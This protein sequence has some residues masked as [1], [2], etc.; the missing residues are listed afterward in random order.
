MTFDISTGTKNTF[1]YT[2]GGTTAIIYSGQEIYLNGLKLISGLDFAALGS[3]IRLIGNNTG[4]SGR[5]DENGV[6]LDSITGNFVIYTGTT[7]SRYSSRYF[8]NGLKQ[9][10]NSDYYEGG[11]VDL[12]SGNSYNY[13]NVVNVYDD[14]GNFWN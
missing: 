4:I 11:I 2:G 6:I 14:N 7:F 10:I 12:L 3:T 1:N 8:V 5:L 13:N 9:Q